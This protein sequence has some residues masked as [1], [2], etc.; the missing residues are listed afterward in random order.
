VAAS[1]SSG[2]A[3]LSVFFDATGTTSSTTSR[4]FHDIE[5][6]WNFGETSGPGVGM[7]TQ[8]SRA[9]QS[10]RNVATGPVAAHVF[11]TPGKYTVA[12]VDATKTVSYKCQITVEDPDVVFA[13][14]K[15]SCFSTTGNFAGCPQDAN[16]VKTSDLAAVKEAATTTNSV[17]R[18]LLRRGEK[19]TASTTAHFAVPG[20]GI[21][22]AFGSGARPVIQVSPA[23]GE[24]AVV[25]FSS[26]RTPDMKD[27]RLMDVTIDGSPNVVNKAWAVGTMGGIDQLTLLRVNPNAVRLGIMFSETLLDIHNSSSD[28]AFHG[29]HIWDQLSVVDMDITNMG[30]GKPLDPNTYVHGTY[31]AGE[32]VF[33]AGNSI[34]GNGKQLTGA[35]HNAR[36]TYLGK[37]AIS[38]NS[39]QRPGPVQHNIK[40]HGATWGNTGVS[41]TGGIG[42]GFTRWV[43]ISD[44]LFTS[45]Y[46]G[47]Q[48]TLG[49]LDGEKDSRVKDVILERNLHRSGPATQIGQVI[50][51]SEVTSRNNIFDTTG[52]LYHA[53]IRVGRRSPATQP[54]DHVRVYNNTMF[55]ADAS[56]DFVAVELHPDVTFVTVQNNLA[57]APLDSRRAMISGTGSPAAPVVASNNS[58]DLLVDPLF[59]GP[60]S[61]AAGFKLK[62][63]SYARKAGSAAE[64][65]PRVFS[66]FFGEDRP[67][68]AA[69]DLGATTQ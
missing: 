33:F 40:L 41:G 23:F 42:G 52:A 30:A 46:N 69:S 18:L 6:R 32:R 8:G 53:S 58:T 22:G 1:R 20:P 64:P 28:S 19:W 5:Y 66:D 50:W 62:G 47:W 67:A 24:A 17:R 54:S 21:I 49:P 9:G 4:P 15:T 65:L 48:V 31:L 34:D 51:A 39:L 44:N 61:S 7:W 45:S 10:S 27:W 13:G 60:V 68:G 55:S 3:P 63:G 59:A 12:V 14:A 26:A 43:V 56:N 2:V 57:Y 11:E 16:R 25:S 35:S 37:A 38:N 29:H 36:F